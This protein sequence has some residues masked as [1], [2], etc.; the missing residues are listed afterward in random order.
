MRRLWPWPPRSLAR[1]HA[2]ALR[3]LEQV[4]KDRDQLIV[5]LLA[6]RKECDEAR[7]HAAAAD[8]AAAQAYEPA[9]TDDCTKTR[10][11]TRDE[12]NTFAD[13]VADRLGRSF[14]AYQCRRCP[15]HPAT[16]TRFWHVGNADPE[17]R[18]IAAEELKKDRANAQRKQRLKDGNQRIGRL[19]PAEQLEALRRKV[20]GES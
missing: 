2:Q 4:R 19:I 13:A 12:A 8:R 10:L 15:R 11:H 7:T 9:I 6:L 16:G 3:S 5:A 20:G 18:G 17:F 14:V 1:E